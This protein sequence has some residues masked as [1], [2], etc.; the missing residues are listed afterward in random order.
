MSSSL[1]SK[2]RK[3]ALSAGQDKTLKLKA[4]AG[5]D[6]RSGMW[7]FVRTYVRTPG[8]SVG[9]AVLTEKQQRKRR[10]ES[11]TNSVRPAEAKADRPWTKRQGMV[12]AKDRKPDCQTGS[13]TATGRQPKTDCQA[14]MPDL[15]RWQSGTPNGRPNVQNG[16]P[17][18]G[19]KPKVGMVATVPCDKSQGNKNGGHP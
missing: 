7:A 19:Q 4:G 10:T 6:G 9:P 5:S 3:L 12:T 11:R 2:G 1:H 14:D 15:P 18:D 16:R 8:F 17:K 13:L